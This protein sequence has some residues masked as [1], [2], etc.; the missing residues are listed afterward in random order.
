MSDKIRVVIVDDHAILREGVRALLQL[1]PDI[2]VVGEGADGMQALEQVERL[3][4]DVVLMD[5]AMPGLGGIEASLQLKKLGRRARILILSQYE[6]REY[7]RRLLKAGVSGY[8][9]K[10]SAGAELAN[11]VRAVHRGGLVLDP[12]V[13]RTAMEEAGPAAP[14][15]ADPYESLTDREKQVL[16]LVAEGRSNKEVA[17]VLGISVKTA[18]SHREHVMEK[19]G[20]HNRTELV[21]F[22]I[23][24]GVIRVDE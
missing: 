7:V 13:A 15:E 4:P 3:D 2:E 23:R 12:E 16:K 9:L 17:D 19:L 20:V 18:M 1:Q 5:I 24:K 14:G 6:D 11:A 21:R 8:V 10:K 22:A